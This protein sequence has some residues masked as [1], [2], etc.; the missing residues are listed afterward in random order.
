MPFPKTFGVTEVVLRGGIYDSRTNSYISSSELTLRAHI[1][2]KNDRPLILK[3]TLRLP[4]PL[5]FN[6]TEIDGVGTSVGD[7]L[8]KNAVSDPDDD[9]IG[10]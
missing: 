7:I 10:K 5:P 9:S 4:R 2:N 6:F 8:D 1:V 3:T